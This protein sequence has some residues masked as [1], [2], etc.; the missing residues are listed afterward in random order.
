[1]LTIET[2]EL[3]ISEK[4]KRKVDMICKFAHAKPIYQNGKIK[5]IKNTNLAYVRP[6]VIT[7]N[8]NDYLIFEDKQQRYYKT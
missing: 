6:H 2:K 1:M 8:K 7:I 3:E 4:L 5:S